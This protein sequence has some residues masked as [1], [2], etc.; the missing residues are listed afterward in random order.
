[1]INPQLQHWLF[2]PVF[3][4]ILLIFVHPVP[5]ISAPPPTVP[6]MPDRVVIHPD[7]TNNTPVPPQEQP[8]Q[9]QQQSSGVPQPGVAQAPSSVN[10]TAPVKN[11]LGFPRKF[12]DTLELKRIPRDLNNIAKLNEHF[13][14]FGAITN[15]QVEELCVI[16]DNNFKELTTVLLH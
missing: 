13:Q 4:I 11:R 7:A 10:H 2:F 14:R 8:L 16:L 9:Q 12:S 15:I 6:T 5:G 3:T 1:M